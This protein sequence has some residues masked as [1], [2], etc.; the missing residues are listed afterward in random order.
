[1]PTRWHQFHKSGLVGVTVFLRVL[2]VK[3]L[4]HSVKD[5]EGK[6]WGDAS[7]ALHRKGH[8]SLTSRFVMLGAG[9][10]GLPG[11]EIFH[12]RA[13]VSESV[14]H[15]WQRFFHSHNPSLPLSIPHLIQLNPYIPITRRTS[16]EGLELVPN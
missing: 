13:D 2:V 14:S 4:T 8:E 6:V 9:L 1:M 10:W 11:R 5:V 7:M 3:R 15:S 16:L 12:R